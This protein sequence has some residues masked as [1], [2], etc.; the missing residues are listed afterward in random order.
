MLGACVGIFVIATITC[1]V[2]GSRFEVN[3]LIQLSDDHR[4]AHPENFAVP[5]QSRKRSRPPYLKLLP[6]PC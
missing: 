4:K 5:Q 1:G 6:V 3:V 2:P